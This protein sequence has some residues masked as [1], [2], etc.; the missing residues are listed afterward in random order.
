MPTYMRDCS[1]GQVGY[2]EDP[3]LIID[4]PQSVERINPFHGFCADIAAI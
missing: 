1:L 2:A 3:I 4:E